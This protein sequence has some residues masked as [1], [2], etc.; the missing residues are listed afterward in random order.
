MHR[1]RSRGV[2]CRVLRHVRLWP[3][4]GLAE[5]SLVGRYDAPPGLS[6]AAGRPLEAA[7]TRRRIVL[8]VRTITNQPKV[9]SKPSGLQ[10][11]SLFGRGEPAASG[12]SRTIRV[13]HHSAAAASAPWQHT[14]SGSPES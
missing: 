13:R 4:Q 11:S 8:D 7:V 5:T 12:K 3:A 14:V 6:R 10:S 9:R 2:G 1:R